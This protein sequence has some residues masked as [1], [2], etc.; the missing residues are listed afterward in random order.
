MQDGG[1]PRPKR[2]VSSWMARVLLT[3]AVAL[4]PSN[5]DVPLV[6]WEFTSPEGLAF[7]AGTSLY[8]ERAGYSTTSS[9][10][11]CEGNQNHPVEDH[12]EVLRQGVSGG[13]GLRIEDRLITAS[14][15]AYDGAEKEEVVALFT[16]F[17]VFPED[18]P[19]PRGLFLRCSGPYIR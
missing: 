15:R 14:L 16:T 2:M 17:A 1:L 6:L 19:I 4:L 7:S 10:P 18:V 3:V 8:P 9:Q 13:K 5:P 12:S 11:S